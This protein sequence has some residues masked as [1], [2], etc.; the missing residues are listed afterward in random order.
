MQII[1]HWSSIDGSLHFRK[2]LVRAVNILAELFCI[3]INKISS[4]LQDSVT[5]D[6]LSLITKLT[7]DVIEAKMP[8]Y[9]SS[10]SLDDAVNIP[11]VAYFPDEVT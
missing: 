11:G 5:E 7:N 2:R 3:W 8:V 1:L 4:I 10:L 6:D 9:C